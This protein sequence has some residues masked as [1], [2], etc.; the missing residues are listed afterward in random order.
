MAEHIWLNGMVC[1]VDPSEIKSAMIAAVRDKWNAIRGARR[2]PSRRDIDPLE[3]KEW[4]PYLSL[5]DLHDDPF[6]VYFRLVGTEVARFT[7]EDFSN[8]WLHETDWDP[9]AVEVN[10]ALY[11]RLWEDQKPTYG[12][13]LVDWDRRQKYVFEWAL[14]PLS[15]DG[16]TVSGCLNVDDFSPIAGRT[17]LLR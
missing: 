17:Y 15:E 14:F 3:F 6:R 8:K 10:C 4:L 13:S 1:F 7:E 16:K 5:V 11:R 9:P 12:L 2:F